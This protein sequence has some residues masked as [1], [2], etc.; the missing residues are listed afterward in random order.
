[1]PDRKGI[2]RRRLGAVSAH[3]VRFELFVEGQALQVA[4]DFVQII[5]D[6]VHVRI[7]LADDLE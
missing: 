1:L 7:L 3:Q 5:G 6:F 2:D 4:T